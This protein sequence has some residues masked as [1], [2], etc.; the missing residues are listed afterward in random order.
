MLG[1]AALMC[2]L[3]DDST[4]IAETLAKRAVTAAES[5]D[6]PTAALGWHALANAAWYSGHRDQARTADRKANQAAAGH[7]S[8]FLVA[9][10]TAWCHAALAVD[11]V[12]AAAWIEEGRAVVDGLSNGSIDS[13]LAWLA[14]TVAY[15]RGDRVTAVREWRRAV[16]LAASAENR[17]VEGGALATLVN[18][19]VTVTDEGSARFV[20]DALRRLRAL[21]VAAPHTYWAL[22]GLAALWADSGHL[23][24][25]AVIV[26]FLD[27]NDPGGNESIADVRERVTALVDARPDTQQLRAGGAAMARDEIVVWCIERLDAH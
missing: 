17:I 10:V 16:D 3:F 7:T 19:A 24:D 11:P 26:G 2:F 12:E 22:T 13:T 5:P 1:A 21:G 4:D 20:S 15:G 14:A 6:D 27:G 18:R 23:D 9:H 25:A 8:R